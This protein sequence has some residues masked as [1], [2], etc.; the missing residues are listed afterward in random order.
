M[1]SFLFRTPRRK[2][3]E[4]LVPLA[5]PVNR[6]QRAGRPWVFSQLGRFGLCSVLICSGATCGASTLAANPAVPCLAQPAGPELFFES[7]P[8]RA[9]GRGEFL[10]RGRNYAFRLEAGRIELHLR[11]NEATP[12][13]PLAARHSL[14]APRMIEAATVRLEFLDANPEAT[15]QG[16]GRLSAK[17]NY[18]IGNDPA[19]WHTGLSAYSKLRVEELYPGIG[20]IYYG[21]QQRLEYDFTVFPGAD[22]A[23]IAMRFGGV[24]QVSLSKEGDLVLKVGAREVRQPKP[25]IYQIAGLKR[26]EVAGDYRIRPNH[27]VGFQIGEYDP[28]LPLVIDP[29]IVYSTYF[30][31]NNA[32]LGFAVKLDPAG[33]IYIAGQTLSAQFPFPLPSGGVQGKFGGG[34]Y[35]GDAFVA[36]FDNSGT[37]LIY[38]TYLGGY[39][40]DGAL[41]LSVDSAGHAY[42]GGFTQ[43]PNFP[44]ANAFYPQ[45]SGLADPSVGIYNA[46]GFITELNTSGSSMLYSTYFG[47]S[48][49]DIIDGI[50]ADDSGYAYVTGL[51]HSTDF[52]TYH[53]LTGQS[54]Y[55]G[56]ITKAFV[57]RWGPGGQAVVYSTYLGG[58]ANDEGQ[59]IAADSQ[60]FAYVVGFTGST[61]FPVTTN[62]F[63]WRLNNTGNTDY[64]Y[65]AFVCKFS[66]SGSLAYSTFLGGYYNDF[67]Y[68]IR[69]DGGGNIYVTGPFQ[70]LDFPVTVTNVPGLTGAHNS[71]YDGFLT[72]FDTNGKLVYSAIFGGSG[73][74][75]AWDLAVD[76]SGN[77]FVVGSTTSSDFPTTN[78]F[79]PFRT[80]NAGASD[81][82]ITAVNSNATAVLYSAYLG[83]SG[84]DTGYGV[85]VDS[86]SSAYL[87]GSTSSG[88]F[89]TTPGARQRSLDG[90]SDAFLTKIRLLNPALS[91]ART[92]NSLSLKWPATAKDFVLESAP[93]LL[94]P[95]QWA[96]VG[97]SPSL[98]TGV[99]TVTVPTV[100]GSEV[101]RLR[102]P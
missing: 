85:A 60:G 88:N 1:T 10:A 18:L 29:V 73:T 49:A 84:N 48:D 69:T 90:S 32:D 31:G 78:V 14:T 51:T 30:G 89:P 100:S 66:P 36:K 64:A 38:F 21:N 5:P 59:G 55:Q 70:S 15:I 77:A 93:S 8:D 9:G 50:A 34:T 75:T 98:T 7:G 62:A 26:V 53:A 71:S 57:A 72:K 52:P 68:R 63:Q 22:P 74:D 54:S 6:G 19:Q 25:I 44:T 20:L 17:I 86:E 97:Q 102:R 79:S 37:N 43:S 67:G 27:T 33:N 4:R 13:S 81:V 3:R 87:V 82:F 99:W 24:E 94:P 80:S 40:E 83:G 96:P 28:R 39:G 2:P 101:F 45:I 58:S 47:G 61:N 95:V 23:K 42:V 12:S 92:G 65:D 91:M 46:D 76:P 16:E 41:D 11:H 35:N 56:A